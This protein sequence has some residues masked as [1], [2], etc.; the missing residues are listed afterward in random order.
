VSYAKLM[1][2]WREVLP[3]GAFLDVHY[4][5]IVADKETEARRLIEYCGLEW[6]DTCLDFHN[7]KRAIR[8]ASVT[9]V[10]QP[11][12]KT[13]VER[14]RAYETFLTPLLEALGDLAPK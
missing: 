4:E 14:W 2:H 13:S 3:K 11:I 10:R 8:T 6:D 12:Y 5:D 1:K 9:Q 7:T